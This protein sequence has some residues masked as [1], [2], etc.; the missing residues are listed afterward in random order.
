M[1]FWWIFPALFVTF[2]LVRALFW[3]RWGYGW[4]GPYGYA[5]GY[6]PPPP[7]LDAREELRQRLARGDITPEEY[8]KRR[9]ALAK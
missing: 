9:E 8:E 4:C 1:P 2:F 3:P 6:A 7:P 5:Y